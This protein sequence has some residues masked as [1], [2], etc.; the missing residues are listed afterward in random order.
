MFQRRILE[1]EV[2]DTLQKEAK[3][4]GRLYVQKHVS[5]QSRSGMDKHVGHF[6][7]L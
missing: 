4:Q 2:R 1:E 7:E 6:K 3:Q 5:Q